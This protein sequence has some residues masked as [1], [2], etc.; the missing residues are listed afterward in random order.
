MGASISSNTASALADVSNSITNNTSACQYQ[1]NHND[2]IV[3]IKTCKIF[4]DNLNIKQYTNNIQK[5]SQ[6]VS[7]I[8]NS[9]V[10]NDIQQKLLQTALS[11]VG[12]MGV[13]YANANNSAS[14]TA[15]VSNDIK[16]TVSAVSNQISNQTNSFSCEDSFIQE[17]NI[18]ITQGA[19]SNFLSG[20]NSKREIRNIIAYS[21]SSCSSVFNGSGPSK[22]K[23]ALQNKM[24]A[25]R[26][27][28]K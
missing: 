20:E 15:D 14:M 12:S 19:S 13:G 11:T 9:N 3:S 16:N 1:I 6:I 10:E 2:N 23:N 24:S 21:P 22:F 25:G 26:N 18:N 17:K 8:S 4:G 7:G 5:N 27:P 28:N